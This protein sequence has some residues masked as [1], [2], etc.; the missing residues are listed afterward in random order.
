MYIRTARQIFS[1]LKTA[2]ISNYVIS[3]NSF[4]SITFFYRIFGHNI[5][6]FVFQFD[7]FCNNIGGIALL[8]NKVKIYLVRFLHQNMPHSLDLYVKRQKPDSHYCESG[9]FIV[10]IY[11][12]IPFLL[13]M[14]QV[15]LNHPQEHL[16]VAWFQ[17]HC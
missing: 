9:F 11:P 7:Y 8:W 4:Y 6:T 5:I 13:T 17:Y 16:Q 1:M 14:L 2:H 3:N 15:H 10:G 12:F